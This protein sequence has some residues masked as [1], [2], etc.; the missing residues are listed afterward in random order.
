[1]SSFRRIFSRDTAP[2]AAAG[3]AIARSVPYA[4]INRIRFKGLFH[5]REILSPKTPQTTMINFSGI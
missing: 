3:L 2:E 5:G 1:M 4:G